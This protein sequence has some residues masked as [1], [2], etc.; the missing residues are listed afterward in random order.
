MDDQALWAFEDGH[1]ADRIISIIAGKK[2]T[3]QNELE[4]DQVDWSGEQKS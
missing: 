2:T 3:V 4:R 1:S